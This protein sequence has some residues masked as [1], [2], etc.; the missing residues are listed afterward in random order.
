MLVKDGFNQT[1]I[2]LISVEKLIN[3]STDM[4]YLYV[5]KYILLD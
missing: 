2:A 3:I 1:N 5:Q 4:G